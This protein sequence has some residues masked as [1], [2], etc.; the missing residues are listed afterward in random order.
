MLL[1]VRVEDLLHKLGYKFLCVRYV[2]QLVTSGHL[3]IKIEVGGQEAVYRSQHGCEVRRRMVLDGRGDV[4]CR[5]RKNR[6]RTGGDAAG[7]I[8]VDLVDNML[9]LSR[10]GDA[11]LPFE[12]TQ[13]FECLGGQS[14]ATLSTCV[15]S[16]W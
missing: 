15:K 11:T 4:L 6:S 2:S 7:R 10:L 5:A 13:I 8:A 1:A 12:H 3:A 16:R 14:E 9:L